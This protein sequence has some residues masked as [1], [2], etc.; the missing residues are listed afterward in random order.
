MVFSYGS[1]YGTAY[2]SSYSLEG[3]NTFA[4]EAVVSARDE[5]EGAFSIPAY[6]TRVFKVTVFFFLDDFGFYHV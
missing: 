2:V 6:D 3:V 5:D 4:T 1:A